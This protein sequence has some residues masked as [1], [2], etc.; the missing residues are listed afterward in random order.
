MRPP[1]T[2]LTWIAARFIVEADG[3]T[4]NRYLESVQDRGRNNGR[5][6]GYA[7]EVETPESPA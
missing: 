6:Q 7:A 2:P 1:G 4:S 3:E 5:W